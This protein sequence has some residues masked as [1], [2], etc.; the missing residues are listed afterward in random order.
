MLAAMKTKFEMAIK[1]YVFT[2][3]LVANDW[4]FE[5]L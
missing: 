5:V 3:Q 4:I 2:L 1:V